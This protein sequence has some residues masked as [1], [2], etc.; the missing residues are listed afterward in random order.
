MLCSRAVHAGRVGIYS[1]RMVSTSYVVTQR[2][3]MHRSL[4]NVAVVEVDIERADETEAIELL[5]D[6]NRWG[7]SYDLTFV[8]HDS[9]RELVR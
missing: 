6:V 1:E 5:V 2:L 3:Y 4:K 9:A 7:A 8:T